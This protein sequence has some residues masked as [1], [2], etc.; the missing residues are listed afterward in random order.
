MADEGHRTAVNNSKCTGRDLQ[1][2]TESL[3]AIAKYEQALQSGKCVWLVSNVA[4]DMRK[5][6]Q[7]PGTM[8]IFSS[9]MFRG[10][11]LR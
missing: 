11:L 9:K 1:L 10:P 4:T 5:C 7:M 6:F 2:A 8:T 3:R